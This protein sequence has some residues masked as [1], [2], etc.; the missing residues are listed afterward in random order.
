MRGLLFGI[1]YQL[2]KRCPDSI[3]CV[4]VT[5]RDWAV[6]NVRFWD[7]KEKMLNSQ[8]LNLVFGIC[9][10]KCQKSLQ[11]IIEHPR[12]ITADI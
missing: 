12:P 1:F 10:Y 7:I 8:I 5:H 3:V 11:D 4:L 2:T 9:F 6:I